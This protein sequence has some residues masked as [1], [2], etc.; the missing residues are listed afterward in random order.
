[1]LMFTIYQPVKGGLKLRRD[2]A[3][4]GPGESSRTGVSFIE[5]LKGVEVYSS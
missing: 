4:F 1:M 3:L 2:M 5:V